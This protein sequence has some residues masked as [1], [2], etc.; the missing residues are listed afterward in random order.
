MAGHPL[1]PVASLAIG[2]ILLE[3]AELL[4]HLMTASAT[5]LALAQVRIGAENPVHKRA[6][7]AMSYA[8]DIS[9]AAVARTPPAAGVTAVI[10]IVMAIVGVTVVGGIIFNMPTIRM[11][12]AGLALATAGASAGV[13]LRAGLRQAGHR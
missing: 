4:A 8:T 10:V 7:A 13:I 5:E 9:P 2:I 1:R 12:A 11:S 3:A 6:T